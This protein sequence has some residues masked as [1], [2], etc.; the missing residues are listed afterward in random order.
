MVMPHCGLPP[1]VADL[2]V[3]TCGHIQ[4]SP[5]EVKIRTMFDRNCSG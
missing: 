5:Y 2:S 1:D 4:M 3:P